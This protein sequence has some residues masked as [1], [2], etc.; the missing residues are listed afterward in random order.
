MSNEGLLLFMVLI[1]VV[2]YLVWD[3]YYMGNMEKVK[4]KVDGNIYTVQSLPDKEA[5]A[6]LLAKIRKNLEKLVAHLD[7]MY[8]DDP[9]TKQLKNNFRSDK[10][11]EGAEKGKYTSYSVNKGEKII[12]CLRSK[13]A[14]KKLVELNTIM[15][16]ALHEMGHIAT[17]ST[18]HTP[19][20]WDN[21]R[22]LLEE[23]IQIGI[24]RKQDFKS[25][26]EPYCGITIT[27]SP[28]DKE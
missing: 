28:L 27:D 4:S 6:D 25:K 24:Y 23:A 12:F 10:I 7:K 20:F 19:E 13:D 26:P 21:F 8:A 1:G 14:D 18:G 15:F 9:R 5:A 17:V 3:T 2:A 11:S 16:V 22:W